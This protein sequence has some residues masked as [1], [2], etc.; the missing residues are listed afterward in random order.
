MGIESMFGIIRNYVLLS[1]VLFIAAC[2]LPRGT[3][4]LEE[5][6][7]MSEDIDGKFVKYEVNSEL[8]KTMPGLTE[9][10]RSKAFDWPVED[11][12]DQTLKQG[13]VVTSTIWDA[14]SSSLFI[15]AGQKST[16]L[17][18][19]RIDGSGLIELPYS[20]TIK[21]A[22]LTVPEAQKAIQDTVRSGSPSAQVQ[23]VVEAGPLNS[24]SILGE[25]RKPG[26]YR[27]LEPNFTI[28]TA[29]ALAGGVAPKLVNPQVKLERNSKL[30]TA[31]LKDVL[32]NTD[33]DI[34]ILPDDLIQVVA[35]PREFQV[36]GS[37]GKS[38]I[39]NFDAPDISMRK[40]VA[41]AGGLDGS[42]SNPKGVVLLRNRDEGLKDGQ[43]QIYIFDLTN[44][45]SLFAAD[46]FLILEDD[47]IVMTESPAPSAQLLLSLIAMG[48]GLIR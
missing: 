9:N 4:L 1:L 6:A 12:F 22:G 21:I 31:P 29:I 11:K 8:L 39:L 19:M 35:D 30:Y 36:L 18:T 28:S 32:R 33:I 34:S 46:E 2:S 15:V 42:K 38:Q 25:V 16:T 27:M 7:P 47:L 20:G 5:L 13:D 40:A 45:D 10:V 41:M 44:P 43:S 48:A 37:S 23:I 17:P 24:F 3:G 26:V 14:S